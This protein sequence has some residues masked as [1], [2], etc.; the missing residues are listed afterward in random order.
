MDYKRVKQAT[1]KDGLKI[2]IGDYIEAFN[3][4]E[5]KWTGIEVKVFDMWHQGKDGV[6]LK[7]DDAPMP[8]VSAYHFYHRASEARVRK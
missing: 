8:E 1:G 5:K 7:C 2:R 4:Y 3:F 6:I